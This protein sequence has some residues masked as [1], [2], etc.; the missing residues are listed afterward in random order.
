MD[1]REKF[2]AQVSKIL[3]IEHEYH[4]PVPRRNRWNTRRLGNGRFPGFG[5]VQD[6]GGQVRIMRVGH[7][8]IWCKSHEEAI[9]FLEESC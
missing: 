4:Q 8:T 3:G 2:Y 9:K 6:F 5:L 1:E 7:P